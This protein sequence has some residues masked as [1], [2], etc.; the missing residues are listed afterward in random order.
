MKHEKN[1]NHDVLLK[2]AD[3]LGAL[4]IADDDGTEIIFD[5]TSL[6]SFANRVF[7]AGVEYG[8][9]VAEELAVRE[10]LGGPVNA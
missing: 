3:E 10:K 1:M 4:I 8:L 6:E 5:E 2:L 9:A 7:S